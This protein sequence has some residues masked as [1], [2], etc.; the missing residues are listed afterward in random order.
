[1]CHICDDIMTGTT[2]NL[3]FDTPA[4]GI[5]TVPLSRLLLQPV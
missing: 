4:G 3:D 5:A 2:G 1:V